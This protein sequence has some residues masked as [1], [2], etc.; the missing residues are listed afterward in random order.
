VLES[1]ASSIGREPVWPGVLYGGSL[2]RTGI[3]MREKA[4]RPIWYH[5]ICLFAHHQAIFFSPKALAGHRH[6]LNYRVAGDYALVCSLLMDKVTF[7]E[8]PETVCLY[9]PPGVSL[10]QVA[11]SRSEYYEVRRDVLKLNFLINGMAF[12]LTWLIFRVKVALGYY[13]V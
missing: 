11:R 9:G 3:G 6:P 4:P 1:I 13:Q 8:I 12:G 10:S 2:E 7:R 5:V